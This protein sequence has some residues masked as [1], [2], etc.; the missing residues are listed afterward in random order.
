MLSGLMRCCAGEGDEGGG[1]AVAALSSRCMRN[2]PSRGTLEAPP[3]AASNRNGCCAWI[4][5]TSDFGMKAG[6]SAF[7]VRPVSGVKGAALGFSLSIL[8]RRANRVD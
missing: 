7:K 2:P 1:D 3:A 6:A 5:E 4:R 8:L